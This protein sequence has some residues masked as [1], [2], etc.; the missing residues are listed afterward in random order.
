MTDLL[1]RL[2]PGPML[3]VLED[4]HWLDEAS[5]ELLSRIMTRASEKP[6]LLVLT[7]RDVVSG[8]SRSSATRR[9]SSSRSRR[10]THRFHHTKRQRWPNA[11]GATHCSCASSS[12]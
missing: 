12:R 3:V 8:W 10:V 4:T 6:W 9:S 1:E 5:G 11:P 2:V 7:R